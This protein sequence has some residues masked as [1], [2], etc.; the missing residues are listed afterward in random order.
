MIS[1]RVFFA[2]GIFLVSFA[3]FSLGFMFVDSMKQR[4][5]ER[6]RSEEAKSMGITQTT[7]GGVKI[8]CQRGQNCI[9]LNSWDNKQLECK[10]TN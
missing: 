1:D 9:C 7:V 4:Q 6:E 3:L 10:F 5:I 2:M 8:I